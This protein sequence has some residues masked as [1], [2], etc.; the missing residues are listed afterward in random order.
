M[1]K[2]LLSTLCVFVALTLSAQITFENGYFIDNNNSK[3]NCLIK[4]VDWKNNP[5]EFEY[6]INGS[7]EVKIA[8]IN[9]VAE[10]S[11]LNSSKYVRVTTNIDTSGQ[12]IDQFTSSRSPEMVQ[13]TMFLKVL[14][15]GDANL[16]YFE[17]AYKKRYFF[18]VKDSE[19]EQLIYKGYKTDNS[20]V[21][22]N[23]YYKQQ[24]VLNLESDG[25][26]ESEIVDANYNLN[27]LSK[28]FIKYNNAKGS[29]IT[30][31]KKRKFNDLFNLSVKAGITEAN[32]T[33]I[34]P[35]SNNN[36]YYSNFSTKLLFEYGVEAEFILPF[37]K[38]KWSFIINP[39]YQVYKNK[40]TYKP[41]EYTLEKE[42]FVNYKSLNIPIGVRYYLFLKNKDFRFFIN[43]G[44]MA[45]LHSNDQII[46]S[47]NSSIKVRPNNSFDP[48]SGFGFMYKNYSFEMRTSNID[49]LT[50]VDRWYSPYETTSFIVGYKLF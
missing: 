5:T 33:L 2:L 19:I 15:E 11:I 45:H 3:T 30:N 16:Y 47:K 10:F 21:N 1:K 12:Q 36:F 17:D 39:S 25:I 42:L 49:N 27:D 46:T 50:L 41:Y 48:F 38:G 24:L 18:N 13:Q 20:T 7:D 6:K 31:I 26:N 35:T 37:N 32:L 43:F 4:D 8:T 29:A 23:V 9:E 44:L 22:Y 28:L 40:T 14:V 34:N